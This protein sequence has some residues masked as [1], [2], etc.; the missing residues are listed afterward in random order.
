MDEEAFEG[1]M[2]DSMKKAIASFQRN[3]TC[4]VK[5]EGGVETQLEDVLRRKMEKRQVEY[6]RRHESVLDEKGLIS[7]LT[8]DTK[9]ISPRTTELTVKENT[10]TQIVTIQ[11]G[12]GFKRIAKITLGD[13]CCTKVAILSLSNLPSLKEVTVGEDSFTEKGNG[14]RSFSINSCSSLLRI[15]IGDGSFKEYCSMELHNLPCLRT[16]VLGKRCFYSTPV[17]SLR[18]RIRSEV[19]P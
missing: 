19:V 4:K 6:R 16:L 18:G 3:S 17:F 9:R 12:E 1:M 10:C 13:H 7:V 5:I 8:D 14:P 2:K 11:Y 15:A